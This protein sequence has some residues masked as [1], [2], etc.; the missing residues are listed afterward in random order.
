MNKQYIK[1]D[2]L[3]SNTFINIRYFLEV[4]REIYITGSNYNKISARAYAS[5]KR[6]LLIHQTGW[7]YRFRRKHR[8]SRGSEAISVCRVSNDVTLRTLEA[9]HVNQVN[10]VPAMKAFVGSLVAG[11]IRFSSLPAVPIKFDQQ[12]RI[13]VGCDGVI[14]L[15]RHFADNTREQE[16][17]GRGK[18]H[19]RIERSPLGIS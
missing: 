18:K 16:S 17:Y 3:I 13:L 5:F 15:L 2:N 10:V 11:E 4:R 19:E 8:C 14:I 7:N 12:R 6:N 1:L 9:H